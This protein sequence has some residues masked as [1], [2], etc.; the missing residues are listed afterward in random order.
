ME[1]QKMSKKMVT[2]LIVLGFT[3]TYAMASFAAMP[4][5][6]VNQNLGIGDSTFNNLVTDDCR[7]CHNQNPPAPYPVDATYLPDRHHLLV[8]TTIPSPS[9][10]PKPDADGDGNPDVNYDCLNCHNVVWNPTLGTYEIVED[11]RDC[12]SCH[13]QDDGELS[14]HHAIAEAQAGDCEYCHGGFVDRGLLDDD[15]DG[16]RNA[17]DTDDVVNPA[18]GWVPTYPPS[19]VT[20]WRSGKDIYPY[21]AAGS[22]LNGDGV[23]DDQTDVSGNCVANP[24]RFCRDD[25]DCQGQD[26]CD[27][28]PNGIPDMSAAGT[29]AGACNF[30][31]NVDNN[32]GIPVWEPCDGG[33]TCST[34]GDTCQSDPDCPSGETCVPNN[35]SC[36]YEAPFFPV[37]V[38]ENEETHHSTG[39][40][41]PGQDKCT[42]CHDGTVTDPPPDITLGKQ[43]D[44]RQCENCHGI[45]SLH[46]IQFAGQPTGQPS[47]GTV[48]PGAATND[49]YNGHI[50]LQ[51]DCRGC[52]AYDQ[53]IQ[54]QAFAPGSG[55]VVPGLNT[56]S[57][58]SIEA[59]ASVVLGGTGFVNLVQNPMT[60]VYD[61]TLGS[62]VVLIGADG[63]ET[64]ITASSVSG[65]NVEAAID[66][67]PGNYKIAAK[68]ASRNSN[69]L[70]IA[71]TPNT[72]IDSAT[73]TDGTVTITGSGFSSYLD[74][75][76]SGT[77][78]VATVTYRVGGKKKGT[79]VTETL[80]A[81]IS[82]WSD[83]EIVGSFPTCPDSVDV[84]T[85]FDTASSSVTSS[86]NG[87]GK[88]NGGGNGK[89]KNK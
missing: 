68:K 55:P 8:G 71:V 4:A 39:F 15:G 72:T 85:V 43:D 40:V 24:D 1:I 78:V 59:G 18:N 46:N 73:C 27:T 19:L 22:P 29:Y 5:P 56:L 52:H 58:S 6:P 81:E 35:A 20:P 21:V 16:I 64:V 89:G 79:D 74:A 69:K 2:V 47:D 80:S 60:G 26:T 77:A 36:V 7:W 83:T 17:I 9:D 88:G 37:L 76:D 38:F 53:R 75:A 63:S 70:N 28:W 67:A 25:T 32:G 57:A 31:H 86:G 33:G 82:S 11:F 48:I 54:Q 45:P 3:L 41:L 13:V 66:V 44:I 61:I 14:K 49:W 42:W 23:V 62:D 51:Q 10:V 65:L 84:T 34:S 30:C 12:T 50:G 87:G